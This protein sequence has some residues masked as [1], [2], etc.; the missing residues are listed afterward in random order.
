MKIA[1]VGSCPSSRMLAPYDDPDWEIWAC[2]TDNAGKLPR[3]DA[4][5]EIHGDLGWENPAQWEAG[6]IAWLNDQ[7]FKL[8]AQ[9][10][11]IF[12]KA[13]IFPKEEMVKLFGPYWF[14]STF[15]WMMALAIT[16]KPEVIGLWGCDMAASTEYYTQRPALIYFA[17]VAAQQ[18]ISIYVPPESDVLQPPPLYGYSVSTLMGRKLAVREREIKERLAEVKAKRQRLV[19]GLDQEIHHLT[20]SLDDLDYVRSVW[21]G[22]T[23]KG[24]D[25][26]A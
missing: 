24:L 15:A 13:E 8:Y 6:Y 4:W 2:S 17:Q 25:S 9:L 20:G 22:E 3:V 18:N 1:L 10:P 14:T 16:K 7:P 11:E 21:T 19:Q 23:P 26:D 12:P 5:F